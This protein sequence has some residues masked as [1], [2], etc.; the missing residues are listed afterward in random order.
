MSYR[1]VLTPVNNSQLLLKLEILGNLRL[2]TFH[3]WQHKENATLELVHTSSREM[4]VLNEN[5]SWPWLTKY[6]KCSSLSASHFYNDTKLWCFTVTLWINFIITLSIMYIQHNNKN[7]GTQ[8]KQLSALWHSISCV[9][10]VRVIYAEWC[11]II[12]M[13]SVLELVSV[14]ARIESRV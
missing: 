14:M 10:M 7:S 11:V 12:V 8:N 4:Q 1:Q 13:L 9:I 2:V 6:L 3:K 5:F